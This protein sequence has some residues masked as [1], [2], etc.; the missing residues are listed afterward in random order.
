MTAKAHL[1]KKNI[2]LKE[3]PSVYFIENKAFYCES[4]CRLSNIYT[5]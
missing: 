1:Y 3:L 5:K 4:H 2:Q